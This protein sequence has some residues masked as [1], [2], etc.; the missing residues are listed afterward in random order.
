MK[1]QRRIDRSLALGTCVSWQNEVSNI[2]MMYLLMSTEMNS[3]SW[4]THCRPISIALQRQMS[5]IHAL[6][7][8]IILQCLLPFGL[9]L[10]SR[11][12]F[13]YCRRRWRWLFKTGWWWSILVCDVM[14]RV[15]RLPPVSQKQP[16]SRTCDVT[17]L[18][19][20]IPGSH[21]PQKAR[22]WALIRPLD[23]Q[24]WLQMRLFAAFGWKIFPNTG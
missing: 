12:S 4:R 7:P 20:T 19:I 21:A 11:L 3:L 13:C 22:V 8:H 17:L 15:R 10:V 18:Q 2:A 24:V 6:R 5:L 14:W 16:A 9:S 23:K 1:W